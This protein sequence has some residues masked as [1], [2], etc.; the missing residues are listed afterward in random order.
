M[1]ESGTASASDQSSSLNE[2]AQ[3]KGWLMKRSKTSKRWSK[4]WCCLKKDELLY[5]DFVEVWSSE[6]TAHK[7]EQLSRAGHEISEKQINWH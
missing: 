6:M 5:G 4:Q 3:K 1:A 2:A 7:S